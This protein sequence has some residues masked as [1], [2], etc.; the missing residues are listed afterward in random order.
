M[1]SL[2]NQTSAKPAP[3]PSTNGVDEEK[4]EVSDPYALG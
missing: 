1:V 4:A 3:I 2:S